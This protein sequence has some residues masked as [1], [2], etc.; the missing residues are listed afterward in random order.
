MKLDFKRS[1]LLACGSAA[2]LSLAACGGSET[3]TTE[4]G[5][6][7]TA[8]KLEQIAPPAG[9]KWSEVVSRTA[10]GNYVMGNPDAKVKLIEYG[11]LTCSHCA[12]FSKTSGELESIYVASG[13]VSF[14]FRN[15]LLNPIDMSLSLMARCAGP[16][17]YFPLT[18]NM[19]ASQ[20]DI[21]KLAETAD[22]NALRNVEALP[23]KDRPAAIATAMGLDKF[24]KARGMTDAEIKQCFADP[25][26]DMDALVKNNEEA[27]SKYKLEGT[28]HF[29]LGEQP[30]A[31]EAG[32]PGWGQVK[33]KLDEA[34][35]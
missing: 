19:F 25:T 13:Q 32:S 1:V 17:R 3:T 30:F 15:F 6:T 24:M 4:N 29:V 7:S 5:T 26:K 34:L 18:A 35:N 31:L 10:E 21:F 16:E 23:A 33:A 22:Q 12:D 20:A 27:Q 9:K 14:E 28:P 8:T 2:A 11:S